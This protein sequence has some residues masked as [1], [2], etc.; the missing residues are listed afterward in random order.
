M[1]LCVTYIH[2][3]KRRSTRLSRGLY[4]EGKMDCKLHTKKRARGKVLPQL[5][6]N[7]EKDISKIQLQTTVKCLSNG[8][9]FLLLL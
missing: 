6:T 2:E 9:I 3:D 8:S 4:F 7:F 5:E 1:V